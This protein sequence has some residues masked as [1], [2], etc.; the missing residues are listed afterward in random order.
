MTRR[1]G[2]LGGTFDPIHVG[3]LDAAA[4]AHDALGLDRVL[5]VPSLQPPHRTA[6]PHASPFHRFAMAALAAAT[7]P[8]YQV[9]DLELQGA[10]G[11]SYTIDTLTRLHAAG[12][13]PAE[14][15][16]VTGADAFAEIATWKGYPHL[17]HRAHFVVVARPG[18]P[19]ADV[20]RQLPELA[21]RV[22][23]AAR[24]FAGTSLPSILL[25]DRSTRDVSST[26]IRRARRE[27]RPISGLVPPP[28]EAH[29][30]RHGLYA[31]DAPK[32]TDV[33][34]EN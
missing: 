19:A 17:L 10:A 20:L 28:V 14:L 29:I 4:A 15:F 3:H 27:G 7:A 13:A 1:V 18:H 22:H 34:G 31:G 25:V 8:Y 5:L 23:E 24:Q 6:A 12:L 2:V 21:D 9:S 16:F 11:P 26:A 30:L 32:L 33:H